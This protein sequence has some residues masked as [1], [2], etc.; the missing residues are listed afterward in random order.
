MDVPSKSF[1]K[2]SA[3]P[4]ITSGITVRQAKACPCST[5]NPFPSQAMMFLADAAHA[6][7]TPPPL[8]PS[9]LL[10][11]PRRQPQGQPIPFP[12][13]LPTSRS[14]ATTNPLPG[15][16]SQAYLGRAQHMTQKVDNPGYRGTRQQSPSVLSVLQTAAV[17][18]ASQAP[19]RQRLRRVCKPAARTLPSLGAGRTD[20]P[21]P[22]SWCG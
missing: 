11:L 5:A 7:S 4:R 6:V 13:H 10:R 9:L 20:A 21:S 1:S 3:S 8:L 22:F 16:Q 12:I 17:R 19:H 2:V 15:K 14:S 18:P